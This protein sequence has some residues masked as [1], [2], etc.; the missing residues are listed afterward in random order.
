M[1][2]ESPSYSRID[3]DLHE[4][5]FK[6]FQELIY[7]RYGI[8][9][10]QGHRDTL[11]MGLLA[12]T[13]A[14]NLNSYNQY[15]HY[16]RFHPDR[17]VEFRQLISLITITET[18]FFRNREQFDVLTGH[19]LSELSAGRQGRPRLLRVWSAGCSSGAEPYSL[20]ISILE[21][22]LLSEGWQVQILG[23]DVSQKA[24][25]EARAGW[26]T[27]RT[28]RFCTSAERTKYFRKV[29][30]GYEILPRVKSMVDFQYFNLVEEPFPLARMGGW[31]IIFCRNV[32]IYFKPESTRRVI[33]NFYE[34]LEAGGYLFIGYSESLQQITR[35]LVPIEIGGTYI[36]QKEIS[37][38]DP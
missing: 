10:D 17:E 29:G 30:D 16:L 32:T 21:S 9:I 4:E 24:L 27:E 12:R 20:A 25:Q 14:I 37:A 1:T 28:M 13:T 3:A 23:T 8:F 36:Y 11:R 6:H 18:S 2:E 35:E 5:Q 7:Q 26:Y 33:H 19:V 15:Y 22:P 34:S 31:D 38:G